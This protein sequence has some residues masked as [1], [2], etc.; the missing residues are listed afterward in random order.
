MSRARRDLRW[1]IIVGYEGSA[2]SEDAVALARDLLDGIGDRVVVTCVYAYRALGGRF[3]SGERAIA[4]A[5]GGRRALGN[6]RAERM[7]VP[8]TSAAEGLLHVAAAAHADLVVVGSARGALPGRLLRG[9][10]ADRLLA[11]RSVSVAIA[12]SGY[13]RHRGAVRVVG[14]VVDGTPPSRLAVRTA[15]AIARAG[16]A[17]VRVYARRAALPR[18][19]TGQALEQLLGGATLDAVAP[20]GALAADSEK[21]LDLVVIGSRG[22]FRLPGF[23]R[24]RPSIRGCRCPVVVVR[25]ARREA[26]HETAASSREVVTP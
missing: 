10:T 5:E 25:T 20:L 17:A 21:D 24:G 12:P 19:R 1:T 18:D 7:V 9:S 6:G 2:N 11:R 22:R 8:A 26:R 16:G 3:G 15:G 4:V 23:G 13:G 14:V